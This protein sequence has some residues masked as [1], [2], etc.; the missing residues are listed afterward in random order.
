MKS[1][2]VS[3]RMKEGGGNKMKKSNGNDFDF[4]VVTFAL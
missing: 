2:C 1:H 4:Y 3:M